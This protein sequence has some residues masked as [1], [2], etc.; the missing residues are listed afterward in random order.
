MTVDGDAVPKGAFWRNEARECFGFES[1]LTGF[2][3]QIGS[4]PKQPLANGYAD[5]YWTML[6]FDEP[7]TYRLRI[8]QP[9]HKRWQWDEIFSMDRTYTIRVSR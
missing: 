1:P 5:G 6:R 7:G 9:P 2:S 4:G 3:V 8:T